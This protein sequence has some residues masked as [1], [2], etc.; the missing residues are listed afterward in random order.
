MLDSHQ[1]GEFVQNHSRGSPSVFTGGVDFSTNSYGLFGIASGTY[2]LVVYNGM[3]TPLS[4]NI[5]SSVEIDTVT[6]TT[7]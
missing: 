3:N 1:Y 7:S 6:Y 5:T 2:Y 4:M